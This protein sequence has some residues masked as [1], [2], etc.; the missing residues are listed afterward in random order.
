MQ[1][2]MV[3]GLVVAVILLASF[4][5]FPIA[6]LLIWLI[7]VTVVLGRRPGVAVSGSEQPA[8]ATS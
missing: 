8:L 1:R 6:A 5:F 4:M 7:A 2:S 3:L